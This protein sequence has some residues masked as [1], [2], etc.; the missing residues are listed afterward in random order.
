[1]RRLLWLGLVWL[2][3]CASASAEVLTN[4]LSLT[5]A[6]NAMQ[7][8]GCKKTG[9]E[10]KPHRG[11]AL[12][13]WQIGDGVLIVS[14]SESSRKIV[15][16]AFWFADDRPKSTRQTFEFDVASFD[17]GTGLITIRTIRE[18]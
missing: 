1:M 10:M 8:A 5:V 3:S 9:L 17:T 15:G 7:V 18:K 6:S 2:A 11:A 4:G 13:C 16:L 12:E 14:Y